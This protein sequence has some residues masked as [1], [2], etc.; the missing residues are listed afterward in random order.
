KIHYKTKIFLSDCRVGNNYENCRKCHPTMTREFFERYI[1]DRE[2]G[3]LAEKSLNGHDSPGKSSS[4]NVTLTSGH[5]SVGRNYG[6]PDN[7][8][9]LN[10]PNSTMN[11]SGGNANSQR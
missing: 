2:S 5:G 8:L 1:R 10:F 6:L 4:N 7:R 3:N 9:E 11:W